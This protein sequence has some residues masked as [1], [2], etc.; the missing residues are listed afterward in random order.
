MSAALMAFS[1]LA[2]SSVYAH[3]HHGEIEIISVM[4]TKQAQSTN[5]SAMKMDLSHLETPGSI[6]VYNQDL[7]EAQGAVSLGEV[8]KNDA[9]VSTGNVRRGR[10][11]FYMRGF[12]L[13]PDQSYLR[14]GQFHL[15][16]YSQP[17]ELYERIEVLK[18][19]SALLYGKSTP[20]GMINLVTKRAQQ[21]EF[22][23]NFQQEFG[24][25]GYNKSLLDL[26][27]ALNESGSV[28]ARSILSRSSEDGWREYK[29]GSKATQERFVGA[30]MLEADLSDDTVLSVN[31]DRTEDEGGIDMGPQHIKNEKSG[32]YEL[33]GKR[34]YIWDMPWSLRDSSVE[35]MGFTLNSYLNDDWT[36]SAGFN[37]QRHQRQTTESLYGKVQGIDLGVGEYSL[38]G[39]DTYEQ[40][41]VVTGFFDFKG[42]FYTGDVHHRML[43]GSSVVDY[44]KSGMQKKMKIADRVN[45]NDA[46]TI[47]K[48]EELDYR[49]GTALK[50]V[51]RK[52]YGVYIQDLIEFNDSWHLL[53][54]VRLDREESKEATHN[55]I[56]PK[57]AVMY[58]PT[59]NTTLYTT[60][61]ESFEPKDP[62]SNTEDTNY[63]KKLDAERGESFEVGA[64]G[65][66][67]DGS[68]YVSTAVFDIEK[69]NKAVTDKSG[70]NPIT[71]QSGKVRHKG[72]E[73]SLEGQLSDNLSVLTS[74]MYLDGKIISDPI[75]AG[76]R[77]KDTPQF[78]ACTWFNYRVGDKSQL[79]VGAIYVGE[80]FGD[81]PNYFKK[82]AYVKVDMGFSHT[83]KF[84]NEQQGI[85]S[86]N[87]DNLFDEDYLR[88][89]CNNSAMFGSPRSVKVSFQYKF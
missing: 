55:N 70:D 31:Y 29:D 34:D 8:L 62:V 85:I 1:A 54:G 51:Q 10:E 45:I 9:S 56:L 59:P 77:S 57:L 49:N 65:E 26:G 14:D 74:M 44:Q 67:L 50:Q 36:I 80:R 61:S 22:H 30:L 2:S 48:P 23:F 79:S 69:N 72:V 19:P 87:I 12:V 83:I 60:Y 21:E 58:H 38:R 28:R 37:R 42:E 76:K 5:S 73:F 88:G 89:G 82:D 33:A 13:E 47:G 68:L 66:F 18:G 20:G 11:R 24:S 84:A 52:T 6:S 78:S 35:N 71:T 39:R 86:I 46:I 41:D 15:S 27:G 32:K 3:D 7:I 16:R 25:F 40:F 81:T 53:A 4:G 63:G 75:Y 43:I 64:K 17:I